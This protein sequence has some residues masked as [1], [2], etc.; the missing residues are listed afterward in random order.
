MTT[1]RKSLETLRFT[2]HVANN[3]RIALR[4]AAL[5]EQYAEYRRLQRSGRVIVGLN[6]YGYPRLHTYIHGRECLRAGNYCSLAGS[7]VLG[8]K[9]AVDRVTTYPHRIMLGM[10]GAGE[11]GF[12]TPTGDTIL[13]SDVWTAERSLILSGITIGHGAIVAGGSVVTKDVPPYAMV[14]GNPARLIRYRFDEA[15]I[16]ALLEIR[17]WDWPE[18][19][20]RAAVPLL[21]GDDVDA[22]IAYARRE[23]PAAVAPP[24][25]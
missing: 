24:A 18:E 13:G 9:H 17:W 25:S 5:G 23:S 19:Q 8:G 21:A 3:L 7:Y 20:V 1:T 22:F 16:E 4:N 10:E 15:Q 6:T 11:D 2:Y 12:P 14:G